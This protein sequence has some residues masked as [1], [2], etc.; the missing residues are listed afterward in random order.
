MKK[1]SNSL[2]ANYFPIAT[3]MLAGFMLCYLCNLIFQAMT[4]KK[5]ATRVAG[6]D[7][8][9][10]V[11]RWPGHTKVINIPVYYGR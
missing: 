5:T 10:E 6:K 4:Y 1:V 8:V 11:T 9:S 3:G 7:Y 2:F